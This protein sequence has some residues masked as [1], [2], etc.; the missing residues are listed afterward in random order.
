MG[1]TTQVTER[2]KDKGCRPVPKLRQGKT[3][4]TVLRVQSRGPGGLEQGS[5]ARPCSNS[6]RITTGPPT[7]ANKKQLCKVRQQPS[8][9][10]M[11]LK[12]SYFRKTR[13]NKIETTLQISACWNTRN[14]QIAQRGV[15]HPT[16][17]STC[18]P[19]G[20]SPPSPTAPWWALINPSGCPSSCD[21]PRL[22]S[23][24]SAMVLQHPGLRPSAEMPPAEMSLKSLKKPTKFFLLKT[25]DKKKKSH[26]ELL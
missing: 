25:K 3:F 6:L 4:L 19:P 5:Q 1:Q 12:I 15:S 17:M 2:V 9:Y 21:K 18:R 14:H 11:D 10:N 8:L 26:P 22:G 16:G 7:S 13:K 24:P 20:R 23:A